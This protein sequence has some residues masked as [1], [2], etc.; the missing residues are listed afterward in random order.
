MRKTPLLIVAGVLVVLAAGA[1]VWM[2]VDNA[3]TTPAAQSSPTGP[4]AASPPKT[5]SASVPDD[6][7]ERN[8]CQLAATWVNESRTTDYELAE[9]IADSARAA[10]TQEIRTRGQLLYDQLAIAKASVGKPDHVRYQQ[11]MVDAMGNLR[12]ECA[13]LGLA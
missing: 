12:T 8:A 1:A 2:L 4:P 11:A 7:L 13:K 6:F 3:G 9:S 10:L 5:A